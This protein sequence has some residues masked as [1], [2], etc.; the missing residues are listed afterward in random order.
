MNAAASVVSG[1][2]S[3]VSDGVGVVNTITGR[4]TDGGECVWIDN[5]A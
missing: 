1:G 3:V 5:L 4:V 2:L